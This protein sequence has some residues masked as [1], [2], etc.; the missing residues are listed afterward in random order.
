[1]LTVLLYLQV[2]RPSSRNPR[3]ELYRLLDGLT[4]VLDHA[5]EPQERAILEARLRNVIREPGD[6]NLAHLAAAM[7]DFL[8]AEGLQL[9]EESPTLLQRLARRVD[10]HAMRLFTRRRLKALLIVGLGLPGLLALLE[11]GRLVAIALAPG[12]F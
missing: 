10:E 8:E 12:S 1:M 7:V 5:L 4:E 11:V 9:A 6:A 3:A 2:R